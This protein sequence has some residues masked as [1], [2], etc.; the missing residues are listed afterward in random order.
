MVGGGGRGA[1]LFRG[2]SRGMNVVVLLG[3]GREF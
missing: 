2:F 3:L 1:F